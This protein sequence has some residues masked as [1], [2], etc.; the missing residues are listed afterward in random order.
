MKSFLL[1]AVLVMAAALPAAAATT[2]TEEIRNANDKVRELLSTQV[3]RGSD[4]ERKNAS[5]ITHE[6]RDLFDIGD[7]AK[8]ALV[9]HWQEMTPAQRNSLVDT[10][11]LIVERNYIAQLRSNLSYQIVYNG[12]EKQD[13]D[14][15]VKT[16]IKAQR[17]G[18]PVEIGVDYRLRPEGNGWRAYDVITD[19]VSILKNY[20]SQFN[21][22]IGKE[23]IDGLIR[24][25]KAKL[26]QNED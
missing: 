11:R 1:S 24:R 22:I 10:L 21:R 18:R 3:E 16:T 2:A 14:V 12:E 20:R 4:A 17:G 5:K 7:L 19:D 15:V 9:D 23:G 26:D 13:G 25:M 8:R 6:L